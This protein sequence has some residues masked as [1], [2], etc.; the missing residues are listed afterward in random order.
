MNKKMIQVKH[1]ISDYECMWNGIADLYSEKIGEHVPTFFFFSIAGTGN[2][3]CMADGSGV[4][5]FAWSAGLVK[6]MYRMM[7]P[8]VGFKYQYVDGLPFSETMEKAKMQID[9]D[10][11][12]I[13]GPLDMY[14]LA[15]YP[16]MYHR[17]H[18]P[19][20]YIMMV[21]YDEEAAYVLDCGQP[22]VC[23]IELNELE[24]ALNVEKTEL[25]DKN[26]ICLIEFEEQVAPMIEVAKKG[27]KLKAEQ[28]LEPVV[29]FMGIKVLREVAGDI[30]NWEKEQSPKAFK[31]SLDF[32]ITYTGTVPQPPMRLFGAKE[33]P[34]VRH[35]AAFEKL[36]VVLKLLGERY[37]VPMWLESA[38]I[39][40]EAG[41]IIEEITNVVVDYMLKQRSDLT[42]LPK[43]ILKT[44]DLEEAA[45][46]K[47]L[48]GCE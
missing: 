24:Q 19:C 20:H 9:Q 14:Y 26:S 16:K 27:F 47:L 46:K 40:K 11:P 41:E 30:L 21:G 42:P 22:E 37:Q 28:M 12:V 34:D 32:L 15:Y 10:K 1:E 2:A 35:Q 39:F 29:P 44:A 4:K 17:M 43:L 6:E 45:Y 38:S 36:V 8:I 7:A 18:V 13:L 31:A 3:I 48:A 25:G 33:N 5:R 23:R